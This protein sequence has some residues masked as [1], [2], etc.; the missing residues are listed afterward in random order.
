MTSALSGAMLTVAGTNR[1]ILQRA[2]Q[3]HV[4]QVSL[5]GAVLTTAFLAVISCSVALGVVFHLHWLAAA[6]GGLI[7]GVLI[8]NLDRW[9]V[10]ST[11]RQSHWIKTLLMG[12][13]RVVLAVVIGLV[14]STPLTLLA[15]NGEI[16]AHLQVT[17]AEA[18]ADF[19][20]RMQADPRFTSLPADREQAVRLQQEIATASPA[21]V[22]RNHPEVADLTQRLAQVE[23]DYNRAEQDVACEKE[24]TC[25]SG[26][27]GA[28]PA[29]R[30]KEARRDRLAGERAT[31]IAQL[32]TTKQQVAASAEQQVSALVTDKQA[33]LKALQTKVA[34]AEQ[35]RAREVAANDAAVA[36][37]DGL[38]ARL[39]ALHELEENRPTLKL[40][41][42]VLFGFL[43]ALECLPVLF[44]TI[45]LLGKRSSYETLME[46][47]DEFVQKREL[48][49]AHT[50][51]N[52]AEAKAQAELDAAR[53]R[54]ASQLTAEV[55]AARIVL[56]AQVD[57]AAEAVQH[58]KTTQTARL[59]SE[60]TTADADPR[61]RILNLNN[62][63]V[64]Y[65]HVTPQHHP[66]T[67]GAQPSTDTATPGE[68]HD[69]GN[70]AA[71]GT[72]SLTKP[73]D[74]ADLSHGTAPPRPHGPGA[75]F[76]PNPGHV[77]P[78]AGT[79]TRDSD[80][81]PLP[82]QHPRHL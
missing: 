38:L 80:T 77:Q 72:S 45:L 49:L 18:L 37:D 79:A 27:L 52:E 41:H 82:H 81:V 19:E 21:D 23:A 26:R 55:R 58:W 9:L 70:W 46:A 22:I 50:A 73:I 53:A 75:P 24:G 60:M 68:P 36:A 32:T 5:G 71:A 64:T 30:D 31:L 42:G 7:W 12:V 78:A 6:V 25:G 4:K 14:V 17:H 11:L 28:G 39:Q 63:S 57:L 66:R 1:T 76:E 47:E 8:L 29:A 3:D 48:L 34:S 20:R 74:S 61:R 40:A 33:Q 59:A 35:A 13:P 56:D 2:P 62:V 10:V 54:S 15:F 67:T 65:P 44:K 16:N 69:D 43:T 51:Y